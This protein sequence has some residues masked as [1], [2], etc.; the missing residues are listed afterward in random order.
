[1]PGR[2]LMGEVSQVQDDLWA[3]CGGWGVRIKSSGSRETNHV[4]Q[5]R[6]QWVRE[7]RGVWGGDL[8]SDQTRVGPGA[9]AGWSISSSQ[10]DAPPFLSEPLRLGRDITDIGK[11]LR[12]KS[13]KP[14]RIALLRSH[15]VS[16]V[17]CTRQ[18]PSSRGGNQVRRERSKWV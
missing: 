5:E 9:G 10:H 14:R 17:Q 2:F 8:I 12:P 16:W 3:H 15:R 11:S 13:R 1:M 18:E 4:S 7:K 6:C